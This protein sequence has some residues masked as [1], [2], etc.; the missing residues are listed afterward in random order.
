MFKSVQLFFHLFK[1]LLVMALWAMGLGL[2]IWYP[3]RWWP[4]DH[5][6]PVQIL[7]YLA[8]WLLMALFPALLTALLLRRG[9]L[10][11]TLAVPMLLIG[12]SYAPLFLPRSGLALADTDHFKVM[13]YNIWERNRDP[14]AAVALIIGENPDI[15][16][17][18][19][20]RRPMVQQILAEWQ[21]A[22]PGQPLYVAYDGWGVQTVISRFPI[23]PLDNVFDEGRAQK[24]LLQTAA[25]PLQVWNIHAS[26]PVLWRQHYRQA[27]NLAHSIDQTGGPL[28]VA[29]D[30]NTTDQAEAYSLIDD[31]L[32]NAHWN[33]GWG[34]GFSFPA[35]RPVVKHVPVPLPVVRI[36]H[37]FYNDH[38]FVHR[39]GTLSDS[40]GSDHYP[41]VAEFSLVK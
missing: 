35:H 20:A 14:D 39:A 10:T 19:E 6:L 32:D 37:I 22:T 36:D 25:G 8:P 26:Q 2:I 4:G 12:F 9:W 21:A 5:F 33:A 23:T 31:R 7:N 27:L 11:L 34:F 18:Q 24:V 15:L 30:F 16:L 40:G 3:M 13:S 38:L 1:L 41:V 17:L 28:L 29:G